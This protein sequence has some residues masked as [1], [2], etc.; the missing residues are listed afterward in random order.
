MSP[1]RVA[2]SCFLG[3]V[4][5]LLVGLFLAFDNTS[6]DVSASDV[7]GGGPVGEVGCTIAP[8]DAALNDNDEGPGGEHSRAFFDEVGAECYAA[9]TARFRAA[10]GSGVLALVLLA[11]S[12]VV[13]GRS[14]RSSRSGDDATADA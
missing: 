9:S 12:G 8:W 2:L 13:A 7:N 10:V 6:V 11:A 1:R 5:L 3:A 4:L 14:T